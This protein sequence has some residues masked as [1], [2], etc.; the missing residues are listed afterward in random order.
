MNLEELREYKSQI[1]NLADKYRIDSDSIR[2]FGSV[3]RGEEEKN[4]DKARLFH[5]SD[6]IEHIFAYLQ[7]DPA[8]GNRTCDA[9]MRQLE[10]VGEAC[11]HVSKEV[12][13]ENH[14][15][16]ARNYSYA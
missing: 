15:C 14:H 3:A 13:S 2:V 9:I 6:A 8:R 1:Q 16:L 5:A 7:E 10:I 4:S 11:N 12:K